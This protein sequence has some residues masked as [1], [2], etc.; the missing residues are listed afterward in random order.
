ADLLRWREGRPP[1]VDSLEGAAGFGY[2]RGAAS[3][4]RFVSSRYSGFKSIPTKRQPFCTAATPVVPLP[5]NGSSTTASSEALA[6]MI[7]L[8]SA[9]GFWVGWP[10]CAF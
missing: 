8:S 2:R 10:P 1:S 4:L 5:Q 9:I 3:S 6:S 7:R